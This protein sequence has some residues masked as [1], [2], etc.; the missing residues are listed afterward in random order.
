MQPRHP[1]V[2]VR[3]VA[4]VTALLACAAIGVIIYYAYL[5]MIGRYGLGNRH[6]AVCGLLL[7]VPLMFV[8]ASIQAWRLVPKG[9]ESV[10]SG[11]LLFGFMG[12]TV[13]AFQWLRIKEMQDLANAGLS[14]LAFG[15]GVWLALAARTL[16]KMSANTHQPKPKPPP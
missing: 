1:Q 4:I 2:I 9:I 7:I 10:Y 5:A 16:G 3:I 12:F 11:Y 15:L 13:S 14:L 6:V 8:W